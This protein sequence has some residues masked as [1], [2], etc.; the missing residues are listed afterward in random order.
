MVPKGSG[1]LTQAVR[2]VDGEAHEDDISVWVGKRPEA[3]V[4]FLP[5]CVPEGQLHL[6]HRAGE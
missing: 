4:V 6:T 5:S 1:P 3:I 2:A